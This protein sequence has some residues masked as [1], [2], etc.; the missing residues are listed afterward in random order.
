[1]LSQPIVASSAAGS[2]ARTQTADECKTALAAETLR[3]GDSIRLQVLGSSMLPSIWPGDVVSIDKISIDEIVRGD[4]VVC[5]RDDRLFVHRLLSKTASNN[6]I[7]WE[8]RGDSMAQNDPPFSEGQLLGRVSA[9]FRGGRAI[10]PTRTRSMLARFLSWTICHVDP[11]RNLALR[12]QTLRISQ[13]FNSPYARYRS[14]PA[15][16]LSAANEKGG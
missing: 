7:R 9:I 5:E 1:M 14:M 2:R 12:L 16:L 11:V 6:G 8:T 10:I 4:I 13:R 3:A 15:E